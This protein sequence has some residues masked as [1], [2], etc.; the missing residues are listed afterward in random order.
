MSTNHCCH[1]DEEQGLQPAHCGH[2]DE[3]LHCP[4]H[5]QKCDGCEAYFCNELLKQDKDSGYILCEVCNDPVI[6]AALKATMN[7]DY[8]SFHR[9]ITERRRTA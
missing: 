7:G 6:I 2:A 1:C 4:E 8:Q 3:D 5:A 9:Y